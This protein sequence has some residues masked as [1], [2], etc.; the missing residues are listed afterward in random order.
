ML[1]KG[2]HFIQVPRSLKSASL[3]SCP[4]LQGHIWPSPLHSSGGVQFRTSFEQPR[5]KS[6][7]VM[8]LLSLTGTYWLAAEIID[9]FVTTCWLLLFTWTRHS[10]FISPVMLYVLSN[11]LNR[12]IGP[13]KPQE[14]TEQLLKVL[15]HLYTFNFC[16][17]FLILL[18]QFTCNDHSFHTM[19][20]FLCVLANL[21]LTCGVWLVHI[22]L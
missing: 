22:F 11:S 4:E 2:E 14:V 3:S 8:G 15:K 16:L 6:H 17:L 5:N 12:A 1:R 13:T 10:L 20:W 9:L 18:L 7:P 21:T 19:M